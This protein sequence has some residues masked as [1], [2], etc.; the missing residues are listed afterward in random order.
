MKNVLLIKTENGMVVDV[1]NYGNN[2]EAAKE[3]LKQIVKDNVESEFWI[4]EYIRGI[5]EENELFV[6]WSNKYGEQEAATIVEV[7]CK[8]K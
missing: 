3:E 5:V 6:S 8:G 4:V 2:L 7:E 1:I